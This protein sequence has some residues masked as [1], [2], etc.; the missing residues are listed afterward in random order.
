MAAAPPVSPIIPRRR[1]KS[2]KLP[3]FRDF[4]P[5]NRLNSRLPS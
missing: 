2:L 5:F 3:E 1:L 4:Q